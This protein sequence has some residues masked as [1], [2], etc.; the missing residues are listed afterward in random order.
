MVDALRHARLSIWRVKRRHEVAGLV[1]RNLFRAVEEWLVDEK[2]EA[3]ALENMAGEHGG[4]TW[5][6][7]GT[8]ANPTA[9]R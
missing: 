3:S 9:A 6:L 5:R 1:I 2:L 8:S 4:R 7:P